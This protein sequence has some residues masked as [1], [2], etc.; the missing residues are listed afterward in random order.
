MKK[1]MQMI[2]GPLCLQLL[3]E[4]AAGDGDGS[5]AKSQSN[6]A[7]VTAPAAAEQTKGVKKNP[8][9]DIKYGKQEEGTAD[10]GQDEESASEEAAEDEPI[11]RGAEFER[12]IKGEY[13]EQYDARVQEAIRRR[14]KGSKDAEEKLAK[15]GTAFELIGK[16]YGVD[17]NDIDGIAKAL[18]GDGTFYESDAI[19]NGMDTDVYMRV[20]RAEMNESAI[21][22]QLEL[23][24]RQDHAQQM[25]SEWRQEAEKIKNIYPSLDFDTEIQDENFMSLLRSGID[26]RTAYEVVH[27]DDIISGAMQFASKTVEK[28]L[29]DKIASNKSRPTEN[30]SGAAGAVNVKSDVSKLT[31]ADRDEIARRVARG[32]K[33]VF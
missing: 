12:L 13:K 7:G 15:L 4:G 32:E 11:D 21:R 19:A 29:A 25:Y 18:E 31:R 14:L 16:K 2:A 1:K 30:G 24:E 27:K 17:A 10:A 28:K 26:V 23:R 8:L 9:A 3:A 6:V 20:R 33:I 5:N 22:R